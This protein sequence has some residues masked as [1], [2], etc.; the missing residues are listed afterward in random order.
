M[1]FYSDFASDMFSYMDINTIIEAG[2]CRKSKK[3]AKVWQLLQLQVLYYPV[4]LKW[5]KQ[6][7]MSHLAL[8]KSILYRLF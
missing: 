4:V 7:R 3:Y 2:K 1:L 6:G 5:L 8:A